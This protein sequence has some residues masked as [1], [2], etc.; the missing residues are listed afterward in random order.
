MI[1]WL[2]SS[3]QCS[4]LKFLDEIEYPIS[5]ILFEGLNFHVYGNFPCESDT[6]SER[7][8]VVKIPAHFMWPLFV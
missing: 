8:L 5:E 3:S 1:N 7:I 6:N 4:R 2:P